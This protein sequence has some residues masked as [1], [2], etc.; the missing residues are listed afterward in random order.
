MGFTQVK[1]MG[2]EAGGS[3]WEGGETINQ[4]V[5]GCV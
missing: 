1:Y 2:V 4:E 5:N 3:M